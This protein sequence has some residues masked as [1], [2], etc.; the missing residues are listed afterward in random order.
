M[1]NSKGMLLTLLSVVLMTLMLSIVITYI[2][3]GINYSNQDAQGYGITG[4]SQLAAIVQ[5]S[6]SPALMTSMQAALAAYLPGN[7]VAYPL[8]AT[9]ANAISS[10]MMSGTVGGT[11]YPAMTGSR[12]SDYVSTLSK[13][14][15]SQNANV[16]LSNQSVTVFQP[17]P[18]WLNV[19]Y[20]ALAVV[21]STFGTFAIPLYSSAALP[22]PVAYVN[23][24]LS[25]G[26][27]SATPAQFQQMIPFNALQYAAYER[28][29]LGNLR[30]YQNNIA[31]YSWC[32]SGCTNASTNTVLWVRLPNGI[33]ASSSINVAVAFMPKYVSYG[34][35]NS[36]AGESPLL[37]SAYGQHDNG[38]SVFG[39]YWDFAGTA[40]PLGWTLQTG[41]SVSNGL[42]TAAGVN[43]VYYATYATNS[44]PPIVADFYA[45][46][47]TGAT[48]NQNFGFESATGL[49]VVWESWTGG[50]PNGVWFMCS[51]VSAVNCAYTNTYSGLGVYTID[52]IST[53]SAYLHFNYGS[54]VDQVT[55]QIPSSLPL[56]GYQYQGSGFTISWLRTRAYPPSGVMPS[57]SFGSVV[58]LV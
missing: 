25:N 53:S 37:S 10:L 41:W 49:S 46:L 35:G 22:V 14:A 17:S 7:V 58:R 45:N 36:Y 4:E 56:G 29:D 6:M 1:R 33:P 21:N 55:S 40:A 12:L 50:A 31:L 16:L 2:L 34:T 42:T 8:N 19:T 39:S 48:T 47:P 13:Q 51:Y 20:T 24:T 44:V 3:L 30:L 9:A 23:M 15:L 28:S 52:Y 43:S 11:S 57:T 54:A 27:A 18:L 26:Q 38:A 32:E 5:T